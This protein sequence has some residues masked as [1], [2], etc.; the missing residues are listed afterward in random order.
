MFRIIKKTWT[1]G[2]LLAYITIS[3]CVGAQGSQGIPGIQGDKGE[4]GID[5]QDGENGDDGARG[6]Q[7]LQGPAGPVGP[8]GSVGP[9]GP[10]GD[11]GTIEISVPDSAST[12]PVSLGDACVAPVVVCACSDEP[13]PLLGM[14]CA[15]DTDCVGLSTPVAAGTCYRLSQY[16]VY[17]ICTFFCGNEEAGKWCTANRGTCGQ[18]PTLCI[19]QDGWMVP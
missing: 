3:G 14:H 7:G 8:V 11:S 12:V 15:T 17:G 5:G 6:L 10:Q 18:N 9:Q 1:V 19:P 2:N 13:E 16:Q 4:P